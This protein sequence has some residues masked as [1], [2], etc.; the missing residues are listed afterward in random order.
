MICHQVNVYT[1]PDPQNA[2]VLRPAVLMVGAA[3]QPTSKLVGAATRV[4]SWAS[5]AQMVA[6]T[7]AS[8]LTCLS[9]EGGG[10]RLG[11]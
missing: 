9:A 1:L 10:G 11:G 8:A 2:T 4:Y 5:A 3:D 7:A 6:P